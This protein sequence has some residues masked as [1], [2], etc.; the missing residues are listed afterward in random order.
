MNDEF[1]SQ[2]REEPRAE[3]TDALYKRIAQQPQPRLAQMMVARL[4]FRNSVIVFTLLFFVAAC[5][6]VVTEKRWD[7]IGNMWLHVQRTETID[8]RPPPDFTPQA[9]TSEE[10]EVPP[11]PCW[12]VEEAR[13][14]LR[15]DLRIPTWVPEG[16]TFDNKICGIDRIDGYA[17]LYWIGADQDSGINLTLNHLK[18]YNFATQKYEI[19]EGIVP[20]SVAPGSYDEVQIHGQPAILVRGN[21]GEPFMTRE[22]AAQKYEFKWDKDRGIQLYWV[23]EEV[24]YNLFTLADVPAEDVI[25]IAES[26]R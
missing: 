23:E 22:M 4:T 2:L 6:Y 10:L 8:F 18:G 1:M 11:L 12:S 25:H 26:I 15:F 13:E 14:M 20:N 21:W 17:S 16:F 5:V 3:F 9:N 19:Q 24:M 7:K